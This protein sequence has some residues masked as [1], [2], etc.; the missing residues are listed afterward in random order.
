MTNTAMNTVSANAAEKMTKAKWFARIKEV[1]S[2]ADMADKAGALAFIDHEVE[3][4]EK[5][6][7]SGS[8]MTPLQRENET[9]KETILAV[10]ADFAEPVTVTKLMTD[11]R[12]A[13]RSN[14]KLTALLRQLAETG[15]VEREKD[16]KS[17]LFSLP[18]EE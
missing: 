10:L 18:V 16:K 9:I 2:A 8:G 3:L 7:K 17:T 4:L 11:A 5:K 14:Q 6:R 15:K 13:G 1:V 12:L